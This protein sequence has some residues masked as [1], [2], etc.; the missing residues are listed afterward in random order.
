MQINIKAFILELTIHGILETVIALWG[1][2]LLPQVVI[3]QKPNLQKIG[4]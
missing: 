4:L 2:H 1:S 3:I